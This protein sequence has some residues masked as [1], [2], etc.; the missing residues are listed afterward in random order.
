MEI[1]VMNRRDARKYSYTVQKS[2]A[3][4]SIHT[5]WDGPNWFAKNPH[6]KRIHTMSFYDITH[7]EKDIKAPCREDF[8]GLKEFVD[9]IKDK[10]ELLIVHCDAGRS[11]SAATTTSAT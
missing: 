1:I 10:V 6:I 5:P 8:K 4:I 9:S 7:D 2:C 11:R 3:I